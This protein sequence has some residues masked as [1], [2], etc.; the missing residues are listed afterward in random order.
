MRY[1]QGMIFSC[2]SM[3]SH[4]VFTLAEKT[5]SQEIP[6]YHPR[7]INLIHLVSPEEEDLEMTSCSRLKLHSVF[8]VAV[9]LMIAAASPVLATERILIPTPPGGGV[10]INT[11]ERD[12]A[13]PAS[14]GGIPVEEQRPRIIADEFEQSLKVLHYDDIGGDDKV[15]VTNTEIT[16]VSVDIATNG[17]IYAVGSV[18]AAGGTQLHVYRSTDGGTNWEIWAALSGGA[19]IHYLEPWLQVAEGTENRVLIAYRLKTLTG[20]DEIHVTYSELGLSSGS[21][22]SDITVLAQAGV[23]F[24][25]PRLTTDA[26]SF[27]SYYIYLVAGGSDSGGGDIWFARSTSQGTGFESGYMV[28]SL[29][30]ADREY[31]DPDVSY[32]FGGWVHVS[33]H[34]HSRTGAFNDALRYRRI[35]SYANGGLANWEPMLALTST[36]NGMNERNP[37]VRAATTNNQVAIGYHRREPSDL[38]WEYLR[39]CGVL[40]SIDNGA[41]FPTSTLLDE[42]FWTLSGLE[43]DAA[44]GRWIIGGSYWEAPGLQRSTSTSPTA[45]NTIEVLGDRAYDT[46][47]IEG[48]HSGLALD[49]SRGNRAAMFWNQYQTASTDTLR[50]DAEWHTD[51]GY[52]NMADGFPLALTYDPRSE[53]ALVDLDGNGTLEVVFSDDGNNIQVIQHDGSNLPGWPVNVGTALSVAPVAVG[54]LNLDGNMTVVVGTNDGRV[55]AYDPAGQLMPGWPYSMLDPEPTYVSIG[56]VGPPYPRSII[57]VGSTHLRILGPRGNLHPD[58]PGWSLSAGPPSGPAAIGNIDDDMIGEMVCAFGTQLRDFDLGTSTSRLLR[59]LPEAPSEAVTLGDVNLDGKAEIAVPMPDG[60][61]YLIDGDRNDMP[62][63]PV[64]SSTGSPLSSAAFANNLF[65]YDL[66]IAVAARSQTMHLYYFDGDQQSGFPA[67]GNGWNIYGSPI[68]GMLSDFNSSDLIVGA[69]GAKAWGWD[70]IGRNVEG[71]PMPVDENIYLTGALGDTDGDGLTEV[72]FLTSNQLIMLN[73]NQIRG[74]D[75]S[76]LWPMYMHDARRTGCAD[77]PEDITT[78]I[79][80]D[81]T[82]ITRVSFAAPSPNP[83]T[84]GSVFRFSTPARTTMDLSLYDLKGRRVRTISREEIDAGPHVVSWDGRDTDGRSLA[85]GHYMAKLSLR[86]P[87]VNQELT[88]KIIV[89]R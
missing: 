73:V 53:P 43:F 3:H 22:L 11:F 14:T 38:G 84:N 74:S 70:N 82:N 88:R 51:P 56:A 28:A 47:Y 49:P 67:E 77:C 55:F 35:D 15:V 50:F 42:S 65:D 69:R 61:L 37:R 80:E 85:S 46:N 1:G 4:S 41:A 63:W 79:D 25:T 58:G 40:A 44:T 45:W 83:V 71:W 32:G 13:I 81:P 8:L 16:L 24:E 26:S 72:V 78:A 60:T 87:G 36:A 62:G 31:A 76:R 9:I 10:G 48:R 59:T 34:F 20:D 5:K 64:V 57:A 6:S 33:W 68:M 66:E 75:E 39:D 27:S 23:D 17:D 29:T 19:D 30:T 89:L 12:M 54:D 7:W 86:G 52:P 21:F 2:N 18:E